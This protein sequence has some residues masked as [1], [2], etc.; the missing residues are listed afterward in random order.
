MREKDLRKNAESIEMQLAD[1]IEAG[2][3]SGLSAYCAEK[4]IRYSNVLE[5]YT[6]VVMAAEVYDTVL[7]QFSELLGDTEGYRTDGESV[8]DL[9]GAMEQLYQLVN[10]EYYA[11]KEEVYYNELAVQVLADVQ[12]QCETLL[13][14]YVGLSAEA[15]ADLPDMERQ[16]IEFMLGR[17]LGLYE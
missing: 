3:Y 16:Q 12:E 2:N 17:S 6:V 7:E 15:I 11:Y 10:R 8:S 5:E 13:Q 1:Y 4:G 9:A 14:A